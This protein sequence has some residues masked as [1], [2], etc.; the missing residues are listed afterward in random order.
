MCIRDRYN[1]N[2]FYQEITFWKSEAGS[3]MDKDAIMQKCYSVENEFFL[4]YLRTE[5][6]G[7][8]CFDIYEY[9]PLQASLSLSSVLYYPPSCQAVRVKGN[10]YQVVL[11]TSPQPGDHYEV[12]R[13]DVTPRFEDGSVGTPLSVKDRGHVRDTL[14]F[15]REKAITSLEVRA[16][17]LLKDGFCN[18][19]ILTPS[20]D[21]PDYLG[22]EG[23]NVSISVDKAV[24]AEV[25]GFRLPEALWLLCPDDPFKC[26]FLWEVI[27]VVFGLLALG[28]LLI[29]WKTYRP[30][31]GRIHLR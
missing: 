23:L 26:A 29:S 16:W 24:E 25:F 4:A 7:S 12:K 15:E 9:R 21:A 11:E 19:V 2:D 20:P 10:R 22:R 1:G 14:Y 17:V 8:I 3:W 13:L 6:S 5:Q 30:K 28:A 18:S 31:K 27:L